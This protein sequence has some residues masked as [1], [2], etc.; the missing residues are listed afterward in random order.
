MLFR[1]ARYGLDIEKNQLACEVNC[2]PM[3]CI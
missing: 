3:C 2:F 1:I